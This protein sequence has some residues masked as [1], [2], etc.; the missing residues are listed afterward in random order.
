MKIFF[1]RL[2][3]F[4]PAM[5]MAGCGFLN[6]FA[7]EPTYR[8]GERPSY[9]ALSLTNIDSGNCIYKDKEKPIDGCEYTGKIL[10]NQPTQ[11]MSFQLYRKDESGKFGSVVT[12]VSPAEAAKAVG[13]TSNLNVAL[14]AATGASAPAYTL[15]ASGTSSEQIQV[16]HSV[17]AASHYIA[18]ATFASCLAYA[19]GAMNSTTY[20]TH[21]ANIYENAKAFS[22]VANASA[23]KP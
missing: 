11:N 7:S 23:P 21:L 4:S 5:F 20:T 14:P 6:P 3:I 9:T 12:C 8:Q 19:S 15:G 13:T 1:S 22:P 16:I 10:L 2:F 17:D 18:V